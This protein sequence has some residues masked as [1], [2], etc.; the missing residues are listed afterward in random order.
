MTRS[1]NRVTLLGNLGRDA[2]TRSTPSGVPVTKL[3]IGTSRS[4]KN[5]DSGE[6]KEEITWTNVVLWRQEKLAKHLVKGKQL[7]VAGRLSTRS[8]E[9]DGR[10]V[11]VTEVVADQV[12]LLGGPAFER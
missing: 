7:Y 4:W 12:I 5:D 2:E 3:S 11:Y 9:K 6:W 1:I 8:Y 10:T